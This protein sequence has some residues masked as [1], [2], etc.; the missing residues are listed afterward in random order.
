MK[1]FQSL[2]HRC[3]LSSAALWLVLIMLVMMGNIGSAQSDPYKAAFV[4]T[5]ACSG[6]SYTDVLVFKEDGTFFR[7]ISGSGSILN[8]SLQ[9]KGTWGVQKG[10]LVMRVPGN[11][12]VCNTLETYRFQFL[13]PN[14]VV[15]KGVGGSVMDD[16]YKRTTR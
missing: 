8:A 6:W 1:A 15:F 12:D 13:D 3:A 16:T 2:E 9:C 14:T 4:G 10:I 7:G 5:W 11:G